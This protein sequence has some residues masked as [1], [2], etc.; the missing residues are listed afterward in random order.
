MYQQTKDPDVIIDLE[1]R[2][3]IPRG[4]YLWPEDES[5]ILPTPPPTYDELV[6]VFLGMFSTWVEQVA[7]SNDYDTSLSCISYAN[8]GV[9]QFKA[10][11]QALIKWRDGLWSW[12]NDWQNGF[13]GAIPDVIPTWDEVKAMAP[14]PEAYGW[15]VRTVA[16]RQAA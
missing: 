12:A 3:A 16:S 14:Q 7:Q 2:S 8:S 1:T 13:N 5:Q 4:S 15:V 9:K 6:S 10:D 11:A